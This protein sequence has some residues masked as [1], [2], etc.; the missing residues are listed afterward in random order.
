MAKYDKEVVAKKP[1]VIEKEWVKAEAT[2]NNG[3][4]KE[5]Q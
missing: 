1:Q 2:E 3:S 5:R 4:Q